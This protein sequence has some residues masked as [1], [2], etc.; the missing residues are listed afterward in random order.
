MAIANLDHATGKDAID[1]PYTVSQ[2]PMADMKKLEAEYCGK[3]KVE[4]K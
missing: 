4:G 2:N 3:M 1:T